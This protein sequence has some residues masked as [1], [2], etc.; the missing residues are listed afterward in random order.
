MLRFAV[1]FAH[2]MC[3]EDLRVAIISYIVALQKHEEFII[4]I[5]D[6][7]ANDESIF[8]LLEKFALPHEQ[9]LY[10]NERR[11]IHQT[12]AIRLLEEKKAFAVEHK[13]THNFFEL[14]L[15]KPNDAIVINDFIADKITTSP[16]EIDNFV[17]L[18]THTIPTT[19]FACAC[20]DMLSGITH[21]VA[22]RRDLKKSIKQRCIQEMLGYTQPIT[23]CHLPLIEGGN[24]TL[25][26]LLKEGFLPDAIINYVIALG[27]PT[28]VE[29]FTLP[30]IIEWFDITKLSPD[31]VRL[32]WDRLR[33]INREHLRQM[34]DKK[35]STLFGFADSDI[36]R[37][38]KL[39]LEKVSTIHELETKIKA[40]FA[41][42]RCT[43][44]AKLVQ[45]IIL[46][47]PMFYTYETFVAY[48]KKTSM[49][50]DETLKEALQ[51]LFCEQDIELDLIYPFIKSYITEL[52][53]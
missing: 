52:V 27:Y 1:L 31:S 13:E 25:E 2:E 30:D 20:D 21:I 24:I 47:A 51:T 43:G 39:Y 23:Y 29:I 48:L 32:D 50:E 9:R 4:Y 11:H 45:E 8:M 37:L 3:L 46:Q 28:P 41:P 40:I 22:L 6:S 34:E 18:Q 19:D 49:L 10:Q 17:I 15:H 36:G 33:F 7:H 35:L 26:A 44:N 38:A 12:L 42:K 53:A 16:K 5:D 14:K